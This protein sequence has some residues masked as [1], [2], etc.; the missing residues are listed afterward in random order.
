MTV[1]KTEPTS[2]VTLYSPPSKEALAKDDQQKRKQNNK[3]SSSINSRSSL[4]KHKTVPKTQEKKTINTDKQ[5]LS[6]FLLNPSLIV[7][8]SESQKKE[9]PVTNNDTPNVKTEF[10]GLQPLTPISKKR[11]LKEKPTPENYSTLDL[12]NEKSCT[13][14]KPKRL[15]SVTEI[16]SSEYKISLDGQ[17]AS[18]QGREKSQEPTE[19]PGSYHK[20]KNYLFDRPDLLET[21]LQDYSSMLPAD[22]AEEDQEYFVSVA[23]STLEEWTNKGQQILDQQFQLYQEIIKKRIELSYKFKGIV[24]VINDRADALEEQGQ[25]LEGKIKKVKS[26]AN[27]ILNI[28]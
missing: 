1:I 21:C 2:E 5:D 14:K 20:T 17:N 25:Q 26:L 4:T 7:K 28:I 13:Q 27:E 22:V 9:H 12:K 10:T 23:D 15:S 11:A 8:P 6:A 18:S 3:Q 24:S 19:N 16:N